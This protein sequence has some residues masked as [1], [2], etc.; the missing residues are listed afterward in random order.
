[1]F[2]LPFVEKQYKIRFQLLKRFVYPAIQ[3]GHQF[4][5]FSLNCLCLTHANFLT[6]DS[7]LFNKIYNL[8]INFLKNISPPPPPK[9]MEMDQNN[10]KL[11]PGLYGRTDSCVGYL[12]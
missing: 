3:L 11:F 2:H 4:A 10:V 9:T 5:V 12:I 7:E 1:V 6:V 8:K